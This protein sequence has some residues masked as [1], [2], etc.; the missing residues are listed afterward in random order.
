MIALS[1]FHRTKQISYKLDRMISDWFGKK[2][3]R[4]A[5]KNQADAVICFSMNEVKCFEYLKRKAPSILRVVD[6]ANAPVAFM[7]SIYEADC[8]QA[9]LRHEVPSFWYKKELEK[10][11]YGLSLTQYFLAPSSFVR[12]GLVFCG[13]DPKRIRILPYGSNFSAEKKEPPVNDS[14]PLRFVYV[15]QVTFRKGLPYLLEAFSQINRKDIVLDI[16]GGW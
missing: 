4:Y 12:K 9:D 3:A 16:V 11:Q 1:R 14:S 5:V 7:K 2:V 6:C 15:G 13:V 10:Q 8:F